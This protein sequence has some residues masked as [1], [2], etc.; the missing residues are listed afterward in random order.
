M[1]GWR[2]RGEADG[3]GRCQHGRGVAATKEGWEVGFAPAVWIFIPDT[4]KS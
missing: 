3:G 1:G 2:G 4:N